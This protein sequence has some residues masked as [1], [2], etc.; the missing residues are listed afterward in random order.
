MDEINDSLD[1]SEAP[2]PEVNEEPEDNEQPEEEEEAEEEEAEEQQEEAQSKP[3]PNWTSAWMNMMG[4][5]DFEDDEEEEEDEGENVADE[6]TVP[7]KAAKEVAVT[8]SA[9]EVA[10]TAKVKEAAV[11]KVAEAAKAPAKAP[12]RKIELKFMNDD[13]DTACTMLIEGDSTATAVRKAI[14][15]ATGEKLSAVKL[16]RKQKDMMISLEDSKRVPDSTMVRGVTNLP[17]GGVLLSKPLAIAVQEKLKASYST[18]KF[19]TALRQ[20]VFTTEG[21]PGDRFKGVQNLTF[22]QQKEVLPEFGFEASPDGANN[23]IL[24]FQSC[25]VT[26]NEI[27]NITNEINDLLS[28]DRVK[29]SAKA[30]WIVVG[31]SETGGIIVRKTAGTGS[32]QLGRLATGAI[33]KEEQLTGERLN[34]NKISGDGP[35]SGWVSL[36]FQ[37]K[38]LMRKHTGN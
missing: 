11:T 24:F 8:K 38:E 27:V 14:S 23:L 7:P 36:A 32:P 26:D 3:A 1:V 25:F 4:G 35:D 19:Q 10:V 2:V 37:G 28:Y 20:L 18:E 17:R 21:K 33:V 34:Y 5:M 30:R 16:V 12:P 31:G 22:T 29:D 13:K 9:K 6:P 15:E